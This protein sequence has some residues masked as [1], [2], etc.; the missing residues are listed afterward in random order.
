M[1]F[2]NSS[3]V[4]VYSI[5]LGVMIVL[6]KFGFGCKCDLQVLGWGG[7]GWGGVGWGG[8]GWVVCGAVVMGRVGRGGVG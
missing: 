4:D 5:V 1:V 7:V 6:Y 2:S 3:L 8:V